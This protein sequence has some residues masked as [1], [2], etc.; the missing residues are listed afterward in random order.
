MNHIDLPSDMERREFLKLSAAAALLVVGGGSAS[1]E[2][3]ASEM[4][5]VVTL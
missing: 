3:V 5:I 4:T 2:V 1:A